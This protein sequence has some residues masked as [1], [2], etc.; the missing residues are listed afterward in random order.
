MID[1]AFCLVKCE[2]KKIV[3]CDICDLENLCKECMKYHLNFHIKK[4]N[5]IEYMFKE[6]DKGKGIKTKGKNTEML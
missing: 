2:N 6:W 1:C 4:T 3:D 5:N